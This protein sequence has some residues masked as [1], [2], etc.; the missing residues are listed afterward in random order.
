[1]ILFKFLVKP[2]YVLY[3]PMPMA[4][5]VSVVD[6]LPMFFTV[7]VVDALLTNLG[8]CVAL[9]YSSPTVCGCSH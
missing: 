8:V 7:S 5:A 9:I 6:A 4:L 1:M 2:S 3:M